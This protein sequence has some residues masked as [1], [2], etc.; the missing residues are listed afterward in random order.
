M[1]R[2]KT[3]LTDYPSQMNA[4]VLAE[5]DKNPEIRQMQ[6]PV[7]SKGEV[8]VKMDSSPVNPSDL[9]F[10]R[11]LYTK[12][13]LPVIPGFEGSGIVVATGNDFFARRLLGKRVSCFAPRDGNGT[14]AE[15]MLTTYTM[16]VPLGKSMDIEQASMLMVNPLSALAMVKITRKAKYQAIANTAAASALGQLLNRMCMDEKIPLVNIVRREEQVTLLEEQGA[17][18]VL[19]SSVSNFQD[20]MNV[21]F[22][23]LNV[24]AAFD[25]ISGESAS[26]LLEALPKGGEVIIYGSLSQEGINSDPRSFIFQDKRISGFWLSEWIKDQNILKLLS[27]FKKIQKFLSEKHQTTIH[28]R[29]SLEEAVKAIEEY[30]NKMTSGKVIIKPW[31]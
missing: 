6:V 20:Q 5:Y 9:M 16:A 11:G 31:K 10:L 17:Q 29:A 13:E 8:L 3:T 21:L 23:K 19:D 18:Y 14:W 28:Q 2:M 25:A 24:G 26:N 30:A 7:P 27:Y 15:Y 22:K 4:L 1:E 12:K